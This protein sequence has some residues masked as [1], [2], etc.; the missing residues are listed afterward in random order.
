MKQLIVFDL[1]GTLAAEQIGDRRGDGGGLL[2]A[3]L[4]VAQVAVISGGD[5]PQFERTRRASAARRSRSRTSRS[6][7]PAARSSTNTIRRL[8]K[9]L[10]RRLQRRAE[11]RRIIAALERAVD[12]SGFKAEKTWGEAIE[13]RGSQ[14]TYSAL[15]QQAPLDEKKQLGP[16]F[17]QTQEDPSDARPHRCPIS[18]C[19]RRLDVD[20]RHEARHRQ[21]LR[22]PQTAR[23]PRH[24]DRRRCSTSATRSSQAATTTRRARP[25]PTASKSATPNETKRVIEAIVACAG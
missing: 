21:S 7:R 18:R 23:H 9:L 14:I 3:L 22:H 12:A 15:G 17:R 16:G 4:E 5:Y 6:C 1:D 20:R 13:D 2:A 11:S 19:A 10:F 24:P 8:V 25:A